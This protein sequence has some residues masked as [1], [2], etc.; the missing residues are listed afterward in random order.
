MVIIC[1]GKI[2]QYTAH[3]WQF[4]TRYDMNIP[5][6]VL[7]KEKL[8]KNITITILIEFLNLNLWPFFWDI[9]RINKTKFLKFIV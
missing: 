3:Y 5:S 4:R 1:K 7:V 8:K 2:K 6:Y 9:I